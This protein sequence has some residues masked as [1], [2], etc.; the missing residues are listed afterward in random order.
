MNP[1]QFKTSDTVEI[2]SFP[3]LVTAQEHLNNISIHD[4]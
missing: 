3:S 1:F 4:Q 2:N